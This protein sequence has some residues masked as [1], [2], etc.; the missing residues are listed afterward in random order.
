M[1]IKGS[2]FLVIDNSGARSVQCIQYLGKKITKRLN[3]NDLIV[4]VVKK[5]EPKAKGLKLK[6]KKSDVC[7]ALIVKTKQPFIRNTGIV[8]KASVNSVILLNKNKEAIGTRINGY[9]Y[10]E[11]TRTALLKNIAIA[12][13]II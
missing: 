3:L 7:Y 8:L 4:V 5:M 2:N 12:K 6:I 13:F 11:V 10:K 9:I 1:I